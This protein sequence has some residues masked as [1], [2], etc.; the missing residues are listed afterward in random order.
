MWSTRVV[1]ERHNLCN[2]FNI[3]IDGFQLKILVIYLF[4]HFSVRDR[5]VLFFF[6]VLQWK[7]YEFQFK[8]N[9]F[10]MSRLPPKP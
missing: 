8:V 7:K 4:P 6:H 1:S 10:K 2:H 3:K 9:K 5:L